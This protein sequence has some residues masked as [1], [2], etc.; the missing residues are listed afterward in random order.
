MSWRDRSLR[1]ATALR[2]VMLDRCAGGGG[3][4]WCRSAA[5]CCFYRCTNCDMPVDEN[6]IALLDDFFARGVDQS[7]GPCP[8][9]NG[10]MPKP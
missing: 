7:A 4:C 1:A 3:R 6:G 5:T 2:D 9:C 8:Y 10:P